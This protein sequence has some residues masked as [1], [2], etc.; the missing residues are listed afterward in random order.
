MKYLAYALGTLIL[1]V[2]LVIGWAW[3]TVVWYPPVVDVAT[4]C[5]QPV[6]PWPDRGAATQS[7]VRKSDNLPIEAELLSSGSRLIESSRDSS[8]PNNSKL[9]VMSFN[10]QYMAGKNYVFFYDVEGGPDNQPSKVDTELTLDRVAE[11]IEDENPDVLMLQE[12]NDEHDS[13]TYFVDQVAALQQRLGS[14]AYPCHTSAHYWQAG[15]VLHPNVLGAVSMKLVT[16][17]RYPMT[18]ARRHQLPLMDHDPLTTRFY[19]QRAVLESWMAT[20]SG[21]PVALLNTHFDAWGEGSGLMQ[22]QVATTSAVIDSL[23]RQQIP[24]ILGGD[25]NLLPD[26]G[27]R[28]W[29][30]LTEAH[31]QGFDEQTALAALSDRYRQIP[32]LMDLT[33]SHPEQWYTHFPNDP[34]VSGPDRTLDYLFYSDQWQLNDAYIRQSDTLDV[35]DHLPVIGVFELSEQAPE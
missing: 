20:E 4:S 22:S 30:L 17:S 10:V 11:I 7:P 6:A 29:T 5:D 21:K 34:S 13:R 24:W 3:Q 1:G 28:Q 35:S 8:P 25:F 26:D 9:K 23:E 31:G 12:I 16:L 18:Q 27:N 19:F 33:G 15:L 14:Q 32:S 2:V